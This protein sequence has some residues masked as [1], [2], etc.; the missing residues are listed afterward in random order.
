MQRQAAQAEP[1]RV[2]ES[3]RDGQNGEDDQRTVRSGVQ[4]VGHHLQEELVGLIDIHPPWQ[5]D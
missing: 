4:N 1:H 5:A 3:V 2:D